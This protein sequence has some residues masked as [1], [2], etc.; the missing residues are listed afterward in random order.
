MRTA[1]LVTV[2]WLTVIASQVHDPPPP[3]H[4]QSSLPSP[5]T[6]LPS[7]TTG[8]ATTKGDNR[9]T[10]M[11][12][13]VVRIVSGDRMGSG[14]IVARVDSDAYLVLTCHH[15][16]EPPR[17]IDADG[18]R[19]R[20]RLAPVRLVLVEAF[21][22]GDGTLFLDGS[23]LK[24][25][26]V[27]DVAVVRVR[28]P[29]HDLARAALLENEDGLR[30]FDDTFVVGCPPG[31][32]PLPVRG[33]VADTHRGCG[34]G[35]WLTTAPIVPGYSGGGAFVERDGHYCLAGI[36]SAVLAADEP[37]GSFA[38]VVISLSSVRPL[39]DG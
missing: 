15:C 23:V 7:T 32:P 22:P 24:A 34:E 33:L 37:H 25:D 8:P 36:L 27:L 21:L 28:A 39:L 18:L 38:T 30:L 2:I 3:T 12:C 17:L 4:L 14:V 20:V 6:T 16:I 19:G 35:R 29:G 5:P 10:G 13:P 31:F 9:A 26:P 1:L 11:L